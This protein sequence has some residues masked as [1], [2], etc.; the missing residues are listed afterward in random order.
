MSGAEAASVLHID[1]TCIQRWQGNKAAF[2]AAPRSDVESLHR[3][4]SS[5][6]DDI[7]EDL[8]AFVEEWRVKGL[9]V[10]RVLLMRKAGSLK[11]EFL[12][13]SHAAA[14][15]SISRFLAKNRLSHR[16]ATHVG[17]RNPVEVEAEAKG[18]LEVI[19]PRVNDANRHPDFVI[20]M[21][22]TPVWHAMDA[23]GTIHEMG[24]R[25]INMRTATADSRRITVAVTVTASGRRVQSMVVFKGKYN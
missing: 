24:A 16:I 20:N 12:E 10:S 23:K 21:D 17:Q 15:A 4:P 5:V 7:E 8:V 6:L 18:F 2:S 25:T 14:L 19:V 22:Q 13:K 9:P 11:P 3:G 1:R